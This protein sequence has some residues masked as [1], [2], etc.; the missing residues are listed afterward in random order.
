VTR[1]YEMQTGPLCGDG[2]RVPL[3]ADEAC[4]AE[5]IT[6]HAAMHLLEVTDSDIN[7]LAHILSAAVTRGSHIYVFGNGGSAATASHF[8]CDLTLQ[9]AG[10]GGLEPRVHCLY[11][12]ALTTALANDC[13]YGEVFDAPLRAVVHECGLL[14]AISVSGISANVARALEVG[15]ERSAISTG[16]LG[17]AGG[18][19]MA[20]S[21]VC[22]QVPCGTPGVVESV[23]LAVAH[24][25]M[26]RVRR[27][28]ERGIIG[29]G[30]QP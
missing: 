16:M 23:H 19:A 9:R 8:A 24:E 18:D 21:G 29:D 4:T 20:L 12:I 30:V 13:G 17:R 15:H 28:A 25:L 22:M 3:A 5:T 2:V 14:F 10:T 11:D 6:R 26:R 27:L 7:A 1:A